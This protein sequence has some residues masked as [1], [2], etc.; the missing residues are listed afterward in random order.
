MDWSSLPI[1]I[2][3]VIAGYTGKLK[4]RGDSFVNQIDVQAPAFGKLRSCLQKKA[5][6]Q[7]TN[8]FTEIPF[9]EMNGVLYNNT[10]YG[11]GSASFCRDGDT[12]WYKITEPWYICVKGD[13]L[14]ALRHPYFKH[15]PPWI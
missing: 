8:P 5:Q 11:Y 7:P 6:N 9:S 15:V 4:R 1:D 2:V 12:T 13:P 14:P 3:G 10:F